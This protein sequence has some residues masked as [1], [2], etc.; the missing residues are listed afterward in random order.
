[1]L[2][3][4]VTVMDDCEPVIKDG[5]IHFECDTGDD[6]FCSFGT[7]GKQGGASFMGSGVDAGRQKISKRCFSETEIEE[8][9][10]KAKRHR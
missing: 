1:M 3:N 6:L 5:I 10:K 4:N 7:E 8:E 2:L 9:A